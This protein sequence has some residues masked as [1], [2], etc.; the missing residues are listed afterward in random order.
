MVGQC[1]RYAAGV[2][3]T[4]LPGPSAVETALVASGLGDVG[5][6]FLGYLPRRDAELDALWA[7]ARA[8]PYAAVAFESP[9]RLPRSLA[10]LAQV[11]PD[12]RIAVCRELTKRFEEVVRGS[13]SELGL[14]FA[15]PTRGEVT[16]VLA[17]GAPGDADAPA[18]VDAVRRLVEAGTPRR[19]A[20]DVV[21]GLV[22]TPRNELYRASLD[23]AD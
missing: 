1:G 12:R 18:A 9:R 8:W 6:R 11:D 2:E 22:R 23:D 5:Y 21:S 15:E 17:P 16:I 3:V 14:R 20:A 19:L 7:E 13:A 10:R 4:V